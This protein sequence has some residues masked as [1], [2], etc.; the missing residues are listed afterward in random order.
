MAWEQALI[1]MKDHFLL[2]FR[3]L[4]RTVGTSPE[5]TDEDAGHSFMFRDQP[6][7]ASSKGAVISRRLG[8]RGAPCRRSAGWVR[9]SLL[10]MRHQKQDVYLGLASG[11]YM[12]IRKWTW[13]FLFLIIKGVSLQKMHQSIIQKNIIP[14]ITVPSFPLN[15]SHFHKHWAREWLKHDITF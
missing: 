4:G 8:R 13:M 6:I 15:I 2:L 9:K 14:D 1:N 10:R 12:G 11:M 7:Q 3:S 5:Q